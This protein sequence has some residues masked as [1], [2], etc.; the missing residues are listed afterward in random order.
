MEHWLVKE[1]ME[2]SH[3]GKCNKS[4]VLSIC[5]LCFLIAIFVFCFFIV[6]AQEAEKKQ[7]E[8]SLD[9]K[10]LSKKWYPMDIYKSVRD[11]AKY[12]QPEWMYH[13][14][15]KSYDPQTSIIKRVPERDAP[16][17]YSDRETDK[18]WSPWKRDKSDILKFR[19]PRAYSEPE[20]KKR[21]LPPEFQLPFDEFRMLSPLRLRD[22][23]G[24]YSLIMSH[25]MEGAGFL[26]HTHLSFDGSVDYVPYKIKGRSS[27]WFADMEAS[28]IRISL[29]I[30][31]GLWDR[32]EVGVLATALHYED[33]SLVVARNRQSLL[34]GN[35]IAS[36]LGDTEFFARVKILQSPDKISGLTAALRAKFNTGNDEDLL[37]T[38]SM[39]YGVNL[40]YSRKWRRVTLHANAGYVLPGDVESLE[41]TIALSG[42]FTWGFG[43]A[44]PTFRKRVTWLMQVQGHSSPFDTGIDDLDQHTIFGV[45]G[46]RT[47]W[48]RFTFEAALTRDFAGITNG[49]GAQITAGYIW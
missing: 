1:S 8:K 24:F 44:V 18:T 25:P 45:V 47:Y 19:V 11:D 41:D 27:D 20:K 2:E 33:L 22:L 35:K 48:N 32:A 34:P 40:L 3:K 15:V 13:W 46:A 31:G 26:S 49:A 28:T 39:D 7:R 16:K 5:R 23:T 10:D 42:F 6:H 17:E 30:R 38:G 36:G 37:S 21:E 14:R 29:D 4:P 9:K 43:A 12:R